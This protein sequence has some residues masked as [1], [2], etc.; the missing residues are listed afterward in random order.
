MSDFYAD[1]PREYDWCLPFIKQGEVLHQFHQPTVTE[2][3]DG[4]DLWVG[5]VGWQIKERESYY[6][7]D[8]CLERGHQYDEGRLEDGWAMKP[9]GASWLLYGWRD[10]Y[11]N[12]KD[13]VALIMPMDKLVTACIANKDNPQWRKTLKRTNK[14][15]IG[16][17]ESWYTW[18]FNIPVPWLRDAGVPI[19]HYSKPLGEQREIQTTG[20]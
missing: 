5:D 16:A 8:V 14:P 18:N 13:T 12:S 2:D 3:K 11:A 1:L 4:V 15:T 19:G 6:G 17:V 10:C 20:T 9:S 7:Y